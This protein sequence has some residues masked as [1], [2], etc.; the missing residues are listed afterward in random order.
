MPA[1]RVTQDHLDFLNPVSEVAAGIRS[2]TAL[3]AHPLLDSYEELEPEL[4][5]MSQA[6]AAAAL[7]GLGQD[8]I[9]SA[10]PAIR[11]LFERVRDIAL[12]GDAGRI[13]TM[14]ALRAR[15]PHFGCELA[16][17]ERCGSNLTAVLDGTKDPLELLIPSGDARELENIYRNAPPAHVFNNLVAHAVADAA[18]S[19]PP[20]RILRILEIGAG[21]G[22]TTMAV[23]DALKGHHVEYVF[24]DVSH[25]FVNAAS[26]R[27]AA[28]TCLR[29]RTLDIEHAVS[30]QDFAE[31]SFDLVLAANVLHATRD[32]RQSL[33][34]ARSLLAPNGILILVETAALLPTNCHQKQKQRNEYIVPS[35]HRVLKEKEVGKRQ[36][37]LQPTGKWRLEQEQGHAAYCNGSRYPVHSGIADVDTVH[38]PQQEVPESGRTFVS[39]ESVKQRE[40]ETARLA[41]RASSAKGSW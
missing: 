2:N 41:A 34:H 30:K 27:F 5:S 6:Y 1:G 21:T 20:G 8:P 14:T 35:N 9:L 31:R 15:F 24:T 40:G 16:L 22:A 10:E 11:R 26:S 29:F 13:E 17:L 32:I 33:R 7:E 18:R 4:E 38:G 36:R 12:S 28:E 37:K 25:A 39:D 3:H 19:I 23:V